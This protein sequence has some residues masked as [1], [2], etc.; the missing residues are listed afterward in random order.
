[1]SRVVESSFAVGVE[2]AETNTVFSRLDAL[3][4]LEG[5]PEKVYIES[6]GNAKAFIVKGIPDPYFNSV[7]GLTSED[8]DQ[9]D[10]IIEFYRDHKFGLLFSISFGNRVS[11]GDSILRFLG[12]NP[13]S[14]GDTGL[15][16]TV[17]YSL[18]FYI[19]ALIL[20]YKF[21]NDLGAKLGRALALITIIILL[22]T[23]FAFTSLS[24]PELGR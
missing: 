2:L 8:I 4:N 3:K 9:L 14:N 17:L 19:L 13:W 22:I 23:L 15:H 21:K 18:I 24:V 11:F 7:R 16:Y 5:N 1:M 20:G 10:D 12:L 6:F